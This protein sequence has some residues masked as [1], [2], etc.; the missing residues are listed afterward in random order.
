MLYRGLASGSGDCTVR[1]WDTSTETPHHVCKGVYLCVVCG[2]MCYF[3][4]YTADAV[5][6]YKSSLSNAKIWPLISC[7]VLLNCLKSK[8][9]KWE[10]LA[11][12]YFKHTHTYRE[13]SSLVVPVVFYN[14]AGFLHL[15]SL[16]LECYCSVGISLVS[17]VTGRGFGYICLY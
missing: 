4:K 13:L 6:S 11:V 16:P 3:T 5:M 17:Y 2:Y 8:V 1:L 15:A 12:G 14:H 7:Q 9:I 10:L